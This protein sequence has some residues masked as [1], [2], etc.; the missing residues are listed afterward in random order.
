MKFTLHEAKTAQPGNAAMLGRLTELMFVEILRQYMQQV[1]ADH[2]GWLA[3]LND[4]HVGKA[5]RLMHAKPA[6][7][8][9]VAEL[10]RAIQD[11][12]AKAR[13]KQQENADKTDA[14]AVEAA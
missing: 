14:A 7:N 4:V 1:P 8:W 12:V 3:G 13:K 11:R 10:A 2:G 6:Q 9:T 5:L